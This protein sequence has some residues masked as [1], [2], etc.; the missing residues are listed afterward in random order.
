MATKRKKDTAHPAKDTKPAARDKA[1]PAKGA[2]HTPGDAGH[3]SGAGSA[4]EGRRLMSVM[5][6]LAHPLRLRIFEL[7]AEKPRTTMQVA[8]LLDEPPTRLYHHVNALEKTGLVRLRETR[9]NRG[10]IEKYFEAVAPAMRGGSAELLSGSPAAR[11][12]TRAAAATIFEQ[13]RQDLFAE[14]RD[15]A[16]KREPAP[17]L[18]RML[19][20]TTPAKAEAIRHRVLELVKELKT[21]YGEE[22]KGGAGEKSANPDAERF[23]LTIAFARSWPPRKPE[24]NA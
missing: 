7:L 10:T 5:R 1:H 3:A 11:Q 23:S 24:R 6:A 17:M 16:K 9:P 18:L 21:D 20:S 12:S 19:I 2:A 14:M 4:A 22:K 15:L 13:A 8:E